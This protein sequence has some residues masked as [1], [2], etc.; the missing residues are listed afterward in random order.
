MNVQTFYPTYPESKI[1]R[2]DPEGN[3]IRIRHDILEA[4]AA[5]CPQGITLKTYLNQ[6]LSE[7][8][9]EPTEL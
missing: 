4:A 6:L 3:R 7:I 5:R 2:Y 8:L 9:L 1:P